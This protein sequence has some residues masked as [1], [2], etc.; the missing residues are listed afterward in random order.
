MN[1]KKQLYIIFIF[2][3]IILL[4][5]S[6]KYFSFIE[7]IEGFLPSFYLFIT[8]F[9]HFFLIG[10]LPLL[11]SLT[12]YHFIKSKTTVLLL[13]GFLYSLL[14][15][16]TQ[17][18][19]LIFSQFRYHLS[20]IVLKMVFGKR[21]S[22]IFQF[23]YK[24]IVI[25]MVYVIS[26]FLLQFLFNFLAKKIE[27]KNHELKVKL[28]LTILFTL[29]VFSNLIF[30]WSD[31]NYYRPITQVKNVFPI[32]FPLTSDDLM[33]KMNLVDLKKAEQNKNLN[34]N[35]SSNNINYPLSKIDSN[36]GLK[37]NI[38]YIVIDTWR[39][40]CLN[41]QTTPNIYEFSKN[42]QVFNNHISGSNMTTGGIF[43][44]FY[45]I[46]AT[47]FYSFTEQKIA[48]VFMNELQKQ[49]YKL[50]I[51]GSST[52]E[53][54]PFNLNVFAK[55]TNLRLNSKGGSPSHRDA[56]I[57][58]EW[59]SAIEKND[60]NKP[61]FGFLFYDSAHG[62]D[63]PKNYKKPF[64]PDLEEVNYLDLEDSYNPN[65]LIKRYKNSVHYI[66]NLIGKVILQLKE[67]KLLE[68]TIIVIT[69]DH[70]QEF[71]DS[72][73]GYW[74]HGGNFSKYQI[75]IPMLIFDSS[76][77]PTIYNHPTIHY[78]LTPTVL[79]NYLGVKTKISDYSF[80]NDLFVP[81]QRAS[82]VCGYNQKFA[83]LEKNKITNIYKSGGFEITDSFLNSLDESH[84]NF[85]IVTEELKNLN[86]FYTKK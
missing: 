38:L 44:I 39:F 7:N 78:D 83:I 55:I 57:N 77:K 66:D 3:L 28:T 67:K 13:N 63:Y 14:I 11:I 6:K 56:Q 74:L 4:F 26:I 53:N 84:V 54:P 23:S 86:R 32:F 48:P 12:V 51:Y 2:N 73:K 58:E 34:A 79:K 40:D 19:T 81:N 71:N 52:L 59:L 70:G 80:G 5:T 16:V 49:D 22:D 76:K 15:I 8:T 33:K 21:A 64:A 31:A 82:F 62:F 25:S 9:S 42:C 27:S 37:K 72:K 36:N 1:F 30:A 24:N 47:Y 41:Q 68:N 46:P 65:L 50:Y 75:H 29:L 17:I 18:D 85:D 20:P 10:L 45:G 43:S 61:F 60:S 35:F 69:S